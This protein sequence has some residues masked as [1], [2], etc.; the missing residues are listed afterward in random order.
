MAADGQNNLK[1][2][3][4][5]LHGCTERLSEAGSHGSQAQLLK[6]QSSHMN[7]QGPKALTVKSVEV[8][9]EFF[10]NLH[11]GGDHQLISHK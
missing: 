6:D 11:T 4:R 2:Q 9:P 5:E 3:S 7:Q 1:P 8:V 10:L